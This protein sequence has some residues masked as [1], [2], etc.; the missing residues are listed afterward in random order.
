MAEET[1][2]LTLI[3]DAQQFTEV[4]NKANADLTTLQ[5][6]PGEVTLKAKADKKSVGAARKELSEA[7]EDNPFNVPITFTTDTAALRTQ[8][9]TA[10]TT[11][12][13]SVPIDARFRDDALAN[14][15]GEF[16]RAIRELVGLVDVRLADNRAPAAIRASIESALNQ[17]RI[18][19]EIDI[20]SAFINNVNT[21]RLNAAANLRENPIG[22]R[23]TPELFGL[24]TVRDAVNNFFAEP[25]RVPF[26]F[27]GLVARLAELRR[28]AENYFRTQN[29]I[30]PVTAAVLNF[31]S[32]QAQINQLPPTPI[33]V[34]PAADAASLS[35][36]SASIT[37]YY[38]ANPIP[39]NGSIVISNPQ[40]V[41]SLQ[42]VELP[43]TLKLEA[44]AGVTT[45]A[46][47]LKAAAEAAAAIGTSL[48]GID[49]S[50][51]KAVAEKA[52]ALSKA[53][54]AGR[55]TSVVKDLDF[56]PQIKQ[57]IKFRD[58]LRKLQ[59][60]LTELV[61]KNNLPTDSLK[62]ELNRILGGDT[63]PGLLGVGIVN[64]LTSIKNLSTNVD[65]PFAGL[66]ASAEGASVEVNALALKT[67]ALE[68]SIAKQ[69]QALGLDA[70]QF[71]TFKADVN[72]ANISFKDLD[73]TQLK[74][75][76]SLKKLTEA[77][78]EANKVNSESADVTSLK[79]RVTPTN[80][81]LDAKD[82]T[83]LDQAFISLDEAVKKTKLDTVQLAQA[84]ASAREGA[85]LFGIGI[86][87]NVATPLNVIANLLNK[88]QQ[89][90]RGVSAA[91][92]EAAS[93]ENGLALALAKR[94]QAA[95]DIAAAGKLTSDQ[96]SNVTRLVAI[97]SKEVEFL[98][99]DE[100]TYAK[101]L[102]E[103]AKAQQ[104]VA[105]APKQDA[106]DRNRVINPDLRKSIKSDLLSTFKNLEGAQLAKVAAAADRVAIAFNNAG[107]SAKE[108][109]DAIA[110][111]KSGN[112]QA[113]PGHLQ[114]TVE[115]LNRFQT[116]GVKATSTVKT[117][118]NDLGVLQAT[119]ASNLLSRA[120]TF[121]VTEFTQSLRAA[122]DFQKRISEIRTITQ[123]SSNTFAQFA[124]QVKVLSSELGTPAV[125][126]AEGV[127]QA[128][129]N[130]VVKTADSFTFLRTAI[131]LGQTTVASTDQSVNALSSVINGFGLSSAQ[132]EHIAA[133]L[134]KT[135]ELGRLRLSELGDGLGRVST[136][137]RI[138]GISFEETAAAV[139]T[140]T[141]Q[142]FK[143]QESLT[144]INSLMTQL[145]KPTKEMKELFTDLGVASGEAAI[146]TF[147]FAGFLEI[148]DGQA[149]QGATRVKELLG[150]V[151][152]LRAGLGLT[153]P[154][155]TNFN[156]NL[157]KTREE[158]EATFDAAKKIATESPGFRLSK[159]IIA[160]TNEF[161]SLG[162]SIIGI[163]DK[164]NTAIGGLGLR[165]RQAFDAAP[166]A[167]SLATIGLAINLVYTNIKTITDGFNSARIALNAFS[168]SGVSLN[169]IANGLKGI[170]VANP[171]GVIIAATLAIRTFYKTE[172][173]LLREAEEA[174]LKFA[175]KLQEDTAKRE[176]SLTKLI[177]LEK[178]YYSVVLKKL[179]VDAQATT[180]AQQKAAAE[181]ELADVIT[182]RQVG[183][184]LKILDESTQQRIKAVEEGLAEIGKVSTKHNRAEIEEHLKRAKEEIELTKVRLEADKKAR[185]E[186]N[187]EAVAKE[188]ELTE[189]LKTN[190]NQRIHDVETVIERLANARSE[191]LKTAKES[192]ERIK[193]LSLPVNLDLKIAQA[194]D[195][196]GPLKQFQDS[197]RG[198]DL[199]NI[200]ITRLQDEG[201]KLFNLGNIDAGR[202]S[203]KAAAAL[204]LEVQEQGLSLLKE[205]KVTEDQV[206]ASAEGVLSVK[207]R[208]IQLE[209]Q[210]VK[211]AEERAAL[212]AEEENKRRAQLTILRDATKE[213]IKFSV[214]DNQG[215]L[216]FKSVEEA[217]NALSAKLDAVD[218][219]S[220]L[221][222][223]D[224]SLDKFLQLED[225]KRRTQE[226]FRKET[227]AFRPQEIVTGGQISSG[228]KGSRDQ[229]TVTRT[230]GFA[231]NLF[232]RAA[233]ST[234]AAADDF[235]ES[236]KLINTEIK[237]ILQSA[238][239]SL[240]ASEVNVNAASE[241]KNVRDSI[242][243]A[244]ELVDKGIFE[245]KKKGFSS[246]LLQ[247][248]RDAILQ[249]RASSEA[250]IDRINR[251]NILFQNAGLAKE[252]AN[253]AT[254]KDIVKQL[255]ARFENS[256]DAK[257]NVKNEFELKDSKGIGTGKFDEA[258]FSAAN[259]KLI[260]EVTQRLKATIDPNRPIPEL[261]IIEQLQ[262]AVAA[263]SK[264]VAQ[265][266]AREEEA[267]TVRNIQQTTEKTTELRAKLS[268]EVADTSIEINKLKEELIKLDS[269]IEKLRDRFTNALIAK[270]F[271]EPTKAQG[272]AFR[273]LQNNRP[274]ALF[275]AAKALGE[276]DIALILNK[277]GKLEALKKSD[278]QALELSVTPKDFNT[279]ADG[280]LLV[281]DESLAEQLKKLLEAQSKVTQP[282]FEA[283][284]K[285]T[286]ATNRQQQQ[287]NQ[288]QQL[289]TIIP[290]PDRPI[291]PL[292]EANQKIQAANKAFSDKQLE[293][294]LRKARRGFASGGIVDTVP[295]MLTPGE[296]VINAEATKRNRSLLEYINAQRFDVGG[297]VRGNSTAGG[298]SITNSNSTFNVSVLG[299]E[300][301][302]ATAVEIGRAL[303]REVRRGTVRLK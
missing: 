238:P 284:T 61:S 8:V 297:S 62:T 184:L 197:L 223:V 171:V 50:A 294:A 275:N 214:V 10:L 151:R 242:N 65:A 99:R 5:K 245:G 158:S 78:A 274:G 16:T 135:V 264:Q 243:A 18:Q 126:V 234:T 195:K 42:P 123:D 168:L 179:A 95:R 106:I 263:Q 98:T 232:E 43:V 187:A 256:I 159:E 81:N 30:L 139:Q 39:V 161:T 127:Y 227:E 38:S 110:N 206:R 1:A 130:Q 226:Q 104:A 257:N 63:D 64:A 240:K 87:A 129:S 120:I 252:G 204:A 24:N 163:V 228:A 31:G 185:D 233:A 272:E 203:F 51:L 215:K 33:A 17:P 89:A 273:D 282:I 35:A 170:I 239:K 90:L 57:T 9:Q 124:E 178:E 191:F 278:L 115:E 302:R 194:K 121:S 6:N 149:E 266:I 166:I 118:F 173:D 155:F 100:L 52:P 137:S 58:A 66:R 235:A 79:F 59:T 2:K 27:S 291:L 41:K 119:L 217:Q 77:R 201:A 271:D 285:K 276:T 136:A 32:L 102:Y 34:A 143:P 290:P 208:Q 4:I 300:T 67:A 97:Q 11:P 192:K 202:E 96:I 213:V 286:E 107:A 198:L 205:G 76:A 265:R 167:A 73:A 133:V 113:I 216:K 174:R 267:S 74:L 15:R 209:Q 111:F 56:D 259:Q 169:G 160:V 68:A 47:R 109:A 26:V 132:A 222:P 175:A 172:A 219:A 92:Q 211:L 165:M 301:P 122:I 60:Q 150:D 69:A 85:D 230:L 250:E 3:A 40:A 19:L 88:D 225:I 138:L 279:T 125:S 177:T 190:Y 288:Q 44:L 36:A 20:E 103:V 182:K 255:Q 218:K 270:A 72:S 45:L 142:G 176:V 199:R 13:I 186:H 22:V 157:R 251:A 152:A 86:D 55:V 283:A 269:P 37:A 261:A 180:A 117:A 93:A 231:G 188:A 29:L 28:Q 295:A 162:Q 154:A 145:T 48:Q 71:E 156:A 289:V 224:T 241:F 153:G 128:L 164:L 210:Q 189:N 296:Y 258:K 292:S 287:Q 14:R 49:P 193:E 183:S 293:E 114:K 94:V 299:Q 21:A 112:I 236:A 25:L 237:A 23:I 131:Q 105:N 80:L 7:A 70:V 148:L 212:A 134:F 303:Q 83:K 253:S 220:E 244:L 298:T 12:P 247:E 53:E 196:R 221:L 280:T 260:D 181:E 207:Q 141:I 54:A 116:A 108:A 144:I 248:Q 147:G 254:I 268:K 262:I 249:A 84:L 229:P 246:P 200:E 281:Q 75:V 277:L 46:E 101:A 140:L 146:A 82:Q 91:T